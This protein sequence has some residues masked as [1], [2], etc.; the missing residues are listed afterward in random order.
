MNSSLI[1][2]AALLLA[3]PAL[4]GGV[5]VAS[6]DL[7]GDGR[8]ERFELS[9]N[10][11]SLTTLTIRRP[12]KSDIVARDIAWSLEPAALSIARNGSL[13]LTSSHIGIGRS[14][15]EQTLTI[16]YRGGEYR[17]VGITRGN[18]D[19]VEP[20]L[21]TSCD[22]NLSTGRGMVNNRAVRRPAR[23]V[24]VTAWSWDRSLPAGC[25]IP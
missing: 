24:A 23:A 19:R 2:A 16:A 12:G 5:R 7:D 18:W 6:G 15:H 21:S 8:A 13:K 4:A 14:P 20:A 1:C 25:S 9:D 22:I 10:G 17:V 11:E 3:T